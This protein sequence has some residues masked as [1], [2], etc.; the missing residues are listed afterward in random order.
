MV[1]HRPRHQ[2]PRVV[3]HETDDVHALVTPQL[4]G[5]DVALPQLVGLC[6][7]EAADR[8]VTRRRL[9]RRRDESRLAQDAMRRRIRDT[10]ALEPSEHIADT[11]CAPIRVG[12]LQREHRL[13]FRMLG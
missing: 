6:P 8:F 10:Q 1:R 13:A 2:V 12:I 11:S 3:V 5:E 9:L 4:E 7:F